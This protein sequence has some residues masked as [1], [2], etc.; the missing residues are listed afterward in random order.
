MTRRA[1]L[2][3]FV[4]VTAL[5]VYFTT[6]GLP[7]A[8]RLWTVVLVAGLPPLSVLQARALA[9]VALPSRLALYAQ[10][11]ISLWL[12]A[13]VTAAVAVLS[14]ISARGLGL[15]TLPLVPTLLWTGSLT[16]AAVGLQ[17][18]AHRLGVRESAILAGLLPRTSG[19]RLAFLGVSVSA[20]VCEEIVFRGFLIPAVAVAVGS[21][22]VAAVI[23]AAVFG[24]LHAYQDFSGALRAALLGA[25]LSTVLLAT[26]SVVPAILAHV[27]I[28]VIGGFWLGPRLVDQGGA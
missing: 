20:G 15:F 21:P 28:D 24:L 8:A 7:L 16:L 13:G 11:S 5:I 2:F 14:D 19:E 4:V 27:L 12:L 6:H 10:T 1:P 9:E 23:A 25:V 22:V 3:L 17:L 18:L 26:G